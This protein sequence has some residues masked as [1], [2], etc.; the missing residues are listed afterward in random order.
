MILKRPKRLW[1][2]RQKLK[3]KPGDTG[4]FSSGGKRPHC[5]DALDSVGPEADISEL[6]SYCDSFLILFHIIVKLIIV[7][8]LFARPLRP[9][10]AEVRP[11]FGNYVWKVILSR[12]GLIYF[13]SFVIKIFGT[14]AKPLWKNGVLCTIRDAL[15]KIAVCFTTNSK[16]G[17]SIVKS[18]LRHLTPQYSLDCIRNVNTKGYA[19]KSN[20]WLWRTFYQEWR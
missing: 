11:P 9:H 15:L 3:Q 13:S 5:F 17:E 19:C 16:K 2:K 12:L 1:E 6:M 4:D 18:H 7:R 14:S 10:E 8:R 20:D